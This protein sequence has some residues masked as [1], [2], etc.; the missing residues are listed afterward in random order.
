MF[1]M[2]IAVKYI[3]GAIQFKQCRLHFV[4]FIINFS[5]LSW[6]LPVTASQVFLCALYTSVFC[7]YNCKLIWLSEYLFHWI[8][9]ICT[10]TKMLETFLGI[11]KWNENISTI[12]YCRLLC[13]TF[14]SSSNTNRIKQYWINPEHAT[15]TKPYWWYISPEALI[16]RYTFHILHLAWIIR[17]FILFF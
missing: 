14:N 12:I 9:R 7:F 13:K 2:E 8:I 16:T 17:S 10:K 5:I 3:S 4:F 6:C 15:A 11:T 1:P